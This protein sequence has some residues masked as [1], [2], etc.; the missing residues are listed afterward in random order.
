MNHII[1]NDFLTVTVNS[2]GAELV[3]VKGKDGFEYI[4]C[5]DE[6]Y[7]DGH[8]PLL[9]PA[10]GRTLDST[11]TLGGKSYEMKTHGFARDNEFELVSNDGKKL[12]LRLEA[13]E[14]T[15]RNYPFDFTLC[16][17]FEVVENTLK[18]NFSVQNLDKKVMPYMLGW[19]PGFVLEDEGGSEIGDF[20]LKFSGASTVEWYPLQNGCFVRPFGEEYSLGG[21]SY[22]L[23]EEEIYSNDTMIFKGTG[24]VATL[25]SDKEKHSLTMRWSK[26]LPYFCI[27]KDTTADAR[28]ICLEPWSDVPGGGD[29][30]ENFDTKKMS[31]LSSGESESY[32]Y[33]V[34]FK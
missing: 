2:L 32:T 12:V 27:W 6:R 17:T 14:E 20:S 1:G 13:T 34:E 30:P 25:E 18:V 24:E 15:K 23:N 28:F 10:C 29:A 22:V 21:D 11:Y 4:W 31:R 7:W 16:A 26:N 5:A 9:F 33:S 8:A 3:S 19:H